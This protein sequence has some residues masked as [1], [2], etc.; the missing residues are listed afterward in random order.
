LGLQDDF[1]IEEELNANKPD[2]R[3]IKTRGE[4]GA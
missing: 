1:D 2:L 4:N 3:S